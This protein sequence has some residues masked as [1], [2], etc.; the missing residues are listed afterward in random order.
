MDATNYWLPADKTLLSAQ[1][2]SG[3]SRQTKELEQGI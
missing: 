3:R 1:S 2:R